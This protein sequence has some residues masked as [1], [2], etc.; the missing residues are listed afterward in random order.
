MRHLPPLGGGSLDASS[1][2]IASRQPASDRWGKLGAREYPRNRTRAY[3]KTPFGPCRPH[4]RVTP[5][6]PVSLTDGSYPI[7]TR[8]LP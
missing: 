6:V 4:G 7:H 5:S 8:I 1:N 3:P 2:A